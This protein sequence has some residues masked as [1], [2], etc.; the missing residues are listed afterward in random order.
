VVVS[1]PAS[2]QLVHGV[3]YQ[4][5]CH[6]VVRQE[7]RERYQKIICE[8]AGAGTESIILGCTEIELLISETDSELPLYASTTIHAHAAVDFALRGETE[9]GAPVLA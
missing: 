3:I 7:S 2:R 4:E 8:L 5:L 1:S 6:G 9:P